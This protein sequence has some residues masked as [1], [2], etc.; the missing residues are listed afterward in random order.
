MHSTPKN[1][2][3]WTEI[4]CMVIKIDPRRRKCGTYNVMN[5]LGV[6]AVPNNYNYLLHLI[7]I[8]SSLNL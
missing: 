6:L 1:K 2:H 4:T 5:R 8:Q 7:L 3:H